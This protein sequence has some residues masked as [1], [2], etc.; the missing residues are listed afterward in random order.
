MNLPKSDGL[1]LFP[2]THWSAV[3]RA[4][5]SDPGAAELAIDTLCATYWKPIYWYIRYLGQSAQDAEDLTQEF[6]RE[7]MVKRNLFLEA[8]REQGRLRTYVCVAVKRR[9]YNA[10]RNRERK[11]RGGD[12]EVLPLEFANETLAEEA[13]HLRPDEE[14]DRQWAVALVERVLT[15]LEADYVARRQAELFRALRGHISFEGPEMSQEQIAE[16]LGI[17]VGALRMSLTRLR[18]R[19]REVFRRH[20]AQTVPVGG[21]REIDE[22]LG[23][24][25]GLF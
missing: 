5:G 13:D 17:K 19:F 3:R 6:F 11:K 24:L 10:V 22:E 21:D 4:R 12:Q 15:E 7:L 18:G 9:V 8:Q 23:Y 14:F 1:T 25:I 2:D 16:G 20:V